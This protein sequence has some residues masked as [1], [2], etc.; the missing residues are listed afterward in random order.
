M[1]TADIF[2]VFDASG[3]DDYCDLYYRF[4]IPYLEEKIG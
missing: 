1:N 2:N 3:I 4:S